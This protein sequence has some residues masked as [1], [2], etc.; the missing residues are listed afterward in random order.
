[1]NTVLTPGQQAHRRYIASEEWEATRYWW[2]R[3]TPRR[4]RSCRA[5][6]PRCS[7]GPVQLHHRTYRRAY[8]TWPGFRPLGKER[9][10]DLKPLCDHHHGRLHDFQ[11]RH[12]L[13]VEQASRYYLAAA[14]VR[15]R[16]LPLLLLAVL[17]L[18]LASCSAATV[19]TEPKPAV[20]RIEAP[21]TPCWQGSIGDASQAGCGDARFDVQTTFGDL[22]VA[23]VQKQDDSIRT[24]TIVIEIDG[25]EV[26]RNATSAP[27]GVAQASSR[28]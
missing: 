3:T 5:R 15:R 11:K 23:N 20:V 7:S 17:A 12:G 6:S 9:R 13:S 1:M 14:W 16:L 27:Y 25:R 8:V 18:L 21:P 26:A 2:W 10:R 28:P 4:R 19:D 22:V 24:V